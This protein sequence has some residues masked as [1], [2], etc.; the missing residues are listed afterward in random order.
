MFLSPLSVGVYSDKKLI[1]SLGSNFLF[2]FT[3]DTFY[4]NS[5]VYRQAIVRVHLL[6][7][8]SDMG[9]RL[10]VHRMVLISS[11]GNEITRGTTTL[12][13]PL[14]TWPFYHLSFLL[15]LFV[16]QSCCQLDACPTG[17]QDVADSILRLGTEIDHNLFST[18]ILRRAVVSYR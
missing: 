8:C 1:C 5:L 17:K 7:H 10:F 13:S 14:T 6:L 16:R 2:L 11:K 4:R 15:F 9:L 12:F 3:V 18:V